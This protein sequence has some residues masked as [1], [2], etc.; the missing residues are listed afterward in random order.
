MFSPSLLNTARFG[1]SRASYFFTGLLTGHCCPAGS[2]ASRS[3]PSSSAAARLRMA[4]RRS[5]RP[6]PTWAAT[7]PRRAICSRFDDHVYWSH[8]TQPDRSRRVA[9]AHPVQRSAGAEPVRTG[10]V[11]HAADVPAGHGEDLHRGSLADGARL[12]LAGRRGFVEDTIKVTP[13]LEAARRLPLRIDQWLERGAG[14]RF[15]L[16][17][18]QRRAADASGRR[19]LGA[20]EQS[21]KVS[22][23]S[24]ASALPGMC[25]ATARP[26]SAAASG[27]IT[28]CSTRSII[29]STRPRRSTLRSRS[30]NIA[31]SNLHITPG[32]PPPAGTKVSPSNVQPDIATPAVLDVEPAHRAADCAA[33]FAH[34]GLC[35]FAQLSPD[36]F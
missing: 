34:R 29:A 13:R 22:A 2:P 24:R 4:H 8:G 20:H 15:E 16:R 21:R 31:V 33:H 25:G 7:T 26:R 35:G 18:R 9:A 1:Y 12:A 11:Q 6:A 5:R 14:P 10:I 28:G 17:H 27:S 23:R 32:T 19:Q 3:A 36:S 30:Q